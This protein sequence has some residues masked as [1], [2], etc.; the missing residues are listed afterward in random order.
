MQSVCEGQV[1]YGQQSRKSREQNEKGLAVGKECD[2]FRKLKED[3]MVRE[4]KKSMRMKG[5]A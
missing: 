2:M 4:E 1:V 3:Q 5:L